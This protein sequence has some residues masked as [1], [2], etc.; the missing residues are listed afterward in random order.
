MDYLNLAITFT[1]DSP[2]V[3]TQH[4]RIYFIPHALWDFVHSLLFGGG[5][6]FLR[7]ETIE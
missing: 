2:G 1:Q 5:L 6:V 4:L 3:H 7:K